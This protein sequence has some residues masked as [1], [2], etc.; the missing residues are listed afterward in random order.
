MK[1]NKKQTLNIE[2][3]SVNELL[4]A[5]PIKESESGYV[6]D[7]MY[8]LTWINKKD[9]LTKKE[10]EVAMSACKGVKSLLS[11]L[12]APNLVTAG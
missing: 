1:L 9:K 4:T 2:V 5:S 7:Y 10:F 11:V 8:K 3:Q 12:N 6:G